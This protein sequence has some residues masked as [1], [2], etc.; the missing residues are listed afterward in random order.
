MHSMFWMMVIWYFSAKP[1][2]DTLMTKTYLC[3]QALPNRWNP[4]IFSL[5][6][7]A[8]KTAQ[9]PMFL[10]ITTGVSGHQWYTQT[11]KL[12]IFML[13]HNK[14]SMESLGTT[15]RKYMGNIFV[16]LIWINTSLISHADYSYQFQGDMPL[17]KTQVTPS[18]CTQPGGRQ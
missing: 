12:R 11:L 1:S 4:D 6:G 5:V 13:N 7:A 15:D 3:F 17:W 8:E 14:F 10:H 2:I 16:D 9:I 18:T